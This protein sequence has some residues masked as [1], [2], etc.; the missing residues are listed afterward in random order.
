M[1]AEAVV[2]NQ[3][4][5][6]LQDIACLLWSALREAGDMPGCSI[7]GGLAKKRTPAAQQRSE[8]DSAV[9]RV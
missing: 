8:S 5:F 9:S 3:E 6:G 4:A 1:L 2:N 7:L